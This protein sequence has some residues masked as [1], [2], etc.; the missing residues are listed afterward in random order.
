VRQSY[1]GALTPELAVHTFRNIHRLFPSRIVPRGDRVRPLPPAVRPLG[2]V[3]FRIGDSL[4]T[5]EDYIRLNRVT[6]M[7]VLAEGQV[8]LE[9]YEHGNTARTRWMSMSVAKSITATLV[10]AALHDGSIRSLDD[11]VTAYVPA[12]AGTAWEGVTLRDVLMMASGIRWDET[13]TNPASDRR[14]LLEAQISQVPGRVLSLL[15]ALPRAAP[16]GTRNNYST[17]ETQ[18][19]GAVVRGAVRRSLATYLAERIWQPAGMEADATWWLDS[20]DGT[21]IG[22]SGIAATLR[23][24]ARF[25]QFIPPQ[26]PHRG[27][28]AIWLPLVDAAV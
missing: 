8:L 15:A 5:L 14:R 18:V 9:R 1:D 26:P 19:I 6:G 20:P 13:Y 11:L 21:E 16:P 25:G 10:G 4:L 24:Y 3:Q 17:G 12:L 7:M 2:A 27:T 22:G 23:D 28:P